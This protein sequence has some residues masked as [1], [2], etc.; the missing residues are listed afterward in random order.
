[1]GGSFSRTIFFLGGVVES[2]VPGAP[3][4]QARKRAATVLAKWLL[5]FVA[6]LVLTEAV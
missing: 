2:F 6:F 5:G 3:A 1:M 4:A